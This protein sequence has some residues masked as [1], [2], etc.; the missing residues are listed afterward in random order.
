[1]N[2]NIIPE[3]AGLRRLCAYKA[4]GGIYVERLLEGITDKDPQF[5]E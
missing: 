4:S 1:M 2:C 5:Q 3:I